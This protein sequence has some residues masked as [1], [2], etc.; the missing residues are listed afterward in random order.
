MSLDPGYLTADIPGVGG[1]I[2]V[3]PEDFVVEE[4]PAYLPCGV[5]EHLFVWIEKRD[6]SA[7]Q[8]V[9]HL[10]R[11]L[12]VSRGDIGVAGL[13]DRR[14]VT[15]QF[16]SVPRRCEARLDQ[17]DATGV[18]LLSAVPH[19][20]K[21][22]TGHLKGNRFEV[23][24][25]DVHSEAAAVLP[26]LLSALSTSG[27]PNLYGDQRFGRD[28]GT[29]ALGLELLRGERTERSIPPARRKFLVRLALSS[30]QSWLFNRVL[31]DRLQD[32]LL[33]CVLTGDVMQVVA[34]GGPFVVEDP[35]REQPRYDA[36][37]TVLTGPM[38]GPRMRQPHGVPAGR[39]ARVLADAGL[40]SAQFSRFARLLPGARRPMVIWPEDLEGTP[41]ENGVRVTFTLPPGAYATVLLRELCKVDVDDVTS[42]AGQSADEFSTAPDEA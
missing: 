20:N 23:V 32:G 8:L 9:Q 18:R 28:G 22:R 2:K 1:R 31:A 29:L 25:R 5:G 35:L 34:S 7:E 4:I 3:Q 16:V 24:V 10:A 11:S 26:R 21:L 40:T 38:F 30:V 41:V 14:A 39:E 33:H 12:G 17:I 36:R 42:A 27:V 37:E 19:G 15:R 13:K 6:V